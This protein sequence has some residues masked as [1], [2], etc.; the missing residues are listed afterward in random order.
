MIEEYV[1]W[2]DDLQEAFNLVF[3]RY[4]GYKGARELD[5]PERTFAHLRHGKTASRR[6]PKRFLHANMV[7]KLEQALDSP[8]MFSH[9]RIYTQGEL[10]REGLWKVGRNGNSTTPQQRTVPR[11]T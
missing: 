4:G 10:I 9:K 6:T 3:E 11:T 1:V 7:E 8:G 2:D 5:I